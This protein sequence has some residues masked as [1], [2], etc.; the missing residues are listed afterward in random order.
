[1]LELPVL[2]VTFAVKRETRNGPGSVAASPG[3]EGNGPVGINYPRK[4]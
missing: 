1:L 3:K 4:R 2:K